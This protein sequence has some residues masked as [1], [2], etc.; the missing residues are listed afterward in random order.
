VSDLDSFSLSFSYSFILLSSAW[1]NSSCALRIL[2]LSAFILNNYACK[3]STAYNNLEEFLFLLSFKSI[4]IPS[5]CF[6]FWLTCSASIF[7]LLFSYSPVGI[8]P[9]MDSLVAS[10]SNLQNHVFLYFLLWEKSK[11]QLSIFCLTI[12]T[13]PGVWPNVAECCNLSSDTNL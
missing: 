7:S 1:F 8:C 5:T 3:F 11:T 9:S 12:E 13:F 4:Q 6:A 2:S 10:M